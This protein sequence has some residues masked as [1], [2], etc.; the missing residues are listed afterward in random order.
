MIEKKDNICQPFNSWL[1]LAGLC[2][3]I[4]V[5]STARKALWT[6]N[7]SYLKLLNL[8]ISVHFRKRHRKLLLPLPESLCKQSRSLTPARVPLHYSG[9]ALYCNLRCPIGPPKYQPN[10]PKYK[11]TAIKKIQHCASRPLMPRNRKI[12]E[13]MI[14]LVHVFPSTANSR[15]IKQNSSIHRQLHYVDGDQSQRK[16]FI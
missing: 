14:R 3:M 9:P 1:I 16:V 5:R 8:L 12:L 13:L 10:Q 11:I 7:V 15:R 2:W 6:K 4:I